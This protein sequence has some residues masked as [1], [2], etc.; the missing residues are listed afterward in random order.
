MIS[1][2]QRLAI[3]NWSTIKHDLLDFF[4]SENI[5]IPP[6]TT[7]F[8]LN[9]S[10]KAS[11]DPFRKVKSLT[12]C[13]CKLGWNHQWTCTAIV[14]AYNDGGVAPHVDTGDLKF[15]L[16]LPLANNDKTYAVFYKSDREPVKKQL[17]NS[18]VTYFGFDE[19]SNLQEIDRVEIKEP[20]LINVKVPHGVRVSHKLPRI[21]ISL[22]LQDIEASWFENYP[23]EHGICYDQT[24][25]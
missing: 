5:L 3:D 7:L 18:S 21:V 12:D 17:P 11:S 1:C 23:A 2:Y 13:I 9:D 25:C 8:Y 20:T 4:H 10:R 16:I 19:G 14:V 6:T 15:S 22:R 24:L